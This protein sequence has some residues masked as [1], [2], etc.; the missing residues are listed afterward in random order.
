MSEIGAFAKEIMPNLNAN[1]LLNRISC[2][3]GIKA[4]EDTCKVGGWLDENDSYVV[5]R[6]DGELVYL[7]GNQ[8]SKLHLY[9]LYYTIPQTTRNLNTRY[10]IRTISPSRTTAIPRATP[11]WWRTNRF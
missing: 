8:L 1:D 7:P 2:N 5:A 3:L 6:R 11:S 9:L 4:N 10:T